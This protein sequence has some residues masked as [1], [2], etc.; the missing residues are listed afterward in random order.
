VARETVPMNAWRDFVLEEVCQCILSY[1]LSVGSQSH[2]RQ[3]LFQAQLILKKDGASTGVFPKGGYHSSQTMS[4]D[5]FESEN[6]ALRDHA[7]CCNEMPFLYN[8]LLSRL[9][10][11]EASEP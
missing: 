4:P 7:T 5:F 9:L 2:F 10:L 8:I 6:C 1:V 11:I 3:F